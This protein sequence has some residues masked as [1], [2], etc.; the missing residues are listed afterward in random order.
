MGLMV[1][2]ADPA[3]PWLDAALDPIGAGPRI[4]GAIARHRRIPIGASLTRATLLRHKPGR[5]AV[6]EYRL[7]TP[8][9][10]WSLVA[11]GKIR[12]RGLDDRTPAW[13]RQ[14]ATRV[15]VPPVLGTVPEFRLW[16]QERVPG[17]GGFPAL[18]GPESP[19]AARRIGAALAAFH[20]D[21]PATD[22]VH[23]PAAES[24]ILT[25]RLTAM[26]DRV[27]A[28]QS[29]AERL[30]DRLRAVVDAL[31]AE[32]RCTIHRDCYPDQVLIH[33]DRVTLVDLDLHALGDPALDLGNFIAHL[34]EFAIRQGEDGTRFDTPHPLAA[35]L[36]DGYAAAGGLVDPD[37]VGAYLTLSLARLVA[38][39]TELPGRAGTTERLGAL[40]ERRLAVQ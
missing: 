9:S 15:A 21:A 35:D 29:R 33:G 8:G 3:M 40:V 20:R 6:I 19:T 39:S 7:T 37:A 34:V 10:A 4:A 36:L 32:P 23:G 31:P 17:I 16:L 30:L 14:A 2:V 24:A 13:Q 22:R 38:L 27:P 28:W 11:L 12:A 18:T 1:P 5:R 25:T 26:A